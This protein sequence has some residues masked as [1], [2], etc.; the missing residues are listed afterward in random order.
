MQCLPISLLFNLMIRMIRVFS[1][2][3]EEELLLVGLIQR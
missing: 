2:E 1:R 3:S